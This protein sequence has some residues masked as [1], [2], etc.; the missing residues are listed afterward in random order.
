MNRL[1]AAL[2]RIAAD[3][4]EMGVSWAV[5]GGL[6]VSVRGEPRL[7]RD[8]DVAVAVTSDREAENLIRELRSRGYA[9]TAIV[10]HETA[11][12]LATARLSLE[13][14][15]DG[16]VIDLLFASSG[17]EPE[18]V[19]DAEIVEVFP[20]VRARVASRPHLIAMKVLA[21]DDR[22]RPQDFDDLRSLVARATTGELNEVRELLAL[23]TT[24]GFARQRD[25]AARFD[26]LLGELS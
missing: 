9:P 1:A 23:I 26:E 16:I 17:I 13:D 18:T 5:V 22:I 4:D 12:R 24:R 6:A 25:L 20:G 21:R 10:E 2:K 7:T 8:V 11:A 14:E 19:A 15:T 3:L